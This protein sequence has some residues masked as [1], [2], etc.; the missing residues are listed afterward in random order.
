MA[1]LNIEIKNTDIN[2]S[3]SIVILSGFLDA[4]TFSKFEDQLR[5]LMKDNKFQVVV[6]MK[7]LDYI[8]SA[9]LGVFMSVI[10]EIRQKGGDI[11]LSNLNS[12]VYKVF[13]LLGFT[14]LFQIFPSEE[15]AIKAF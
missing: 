11:K 4:H 14:K 9:G 15:E 7:N 13:D 12:K 10:G 6:Q 1:D 5:T 8:S 2:Q 3:V